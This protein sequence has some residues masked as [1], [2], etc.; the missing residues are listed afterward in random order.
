MTREEIK[1]RIR[2]LRA[3]KAAIR[4]KAMDSSDL[5]EL[6]R[7]SNQVDD[8]LREMDELEDRLLDCEKSEERGISN[9]PGSAP[10]GQL[11]VLATY[12]IRSVQT[13]Q[14]SDDKLKYA[15]ERDEQRASAEYREAF[16]RTMLGQGTP[17]QRALVTTSTGAAVIPTTTFDQV[18]ENIQKAA[19]LLAR[20]RVL[21]IP[22][23]LTVPQSDINTPA[24]WHDEGTEIGDS[25]LPPTSVTL[26]GYELAK[27]FSMSA[28]TQSMSVAAFETYLIQE[29]TRT[30]RDALAAAVISGTGVG[31][32]LGILA[33]LVWNATNSFSEVDV[34]KAIVEG[35]ALLPSNYRQN[36]VLCM[37]STTFLRR[38]ASIVDANGNPMFP[39]D[40]ASGIPLSLLG[41]PIVLDDYMP[42]NTALWCD[43]TY[44]FLNFSQPMAVEV[45][46]EAGFTKATVMYRSLAVVDGK[47]V[48]PAFVKVLFATE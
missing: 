14:R 34:W 25:N 5:Q 9:P 40:L 42:D 35:L 29:L 45:S 39:R 2:E 28:A 20:V 37:S 16:Y 30:T 23:K 26:T 7:M 43:P 8:I 41:K 33:G 32:A 11:N 6:R 31:Q 18:V 12:G 46:R 19:G 38:L 1:T 47:P 36:A 22:G 27:L 48:A 44:Y 3:Q 17:E 10:T 13:N 21:D 15:N 4:A 24:T